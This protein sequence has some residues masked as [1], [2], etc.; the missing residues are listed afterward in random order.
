MFH[1]KQINGSS[2]G[3][4]Q[5]GI[6]NLQVASLLALFVSDHFGGS[7]RSSALV[8]TRKSVS[9]SNYR[10]PFVCSCATGNSDSIRESKKDGLGTVEDIVLL[11]ICERSLQ[12]I[13]ARRNSIV[14]PIG[15]LQ[16][17][18]CRHRALLMKVIYCI[19]ICLFSSYGRSGCF[20]FH[21][22]GV[23]DKK[24]WK[25]IENTTNFYGRWKMR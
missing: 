1:F 24:S 9:G 13:K 14:V 17:G 5:V 12:C 20:P 21:T 7:D 4:G 3:R 22:F 11:D 10:K 8:R 15:A 19:G 16:F 23:F 18:V 2:K 6:D 25:I